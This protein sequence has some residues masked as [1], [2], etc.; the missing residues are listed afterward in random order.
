M[1]NISQHITVLLRRHDCVIVPSIGAFIVDRKHASLSADGSTFT[2][3]QR[4]V[5]FNADITHNDGLLASSIAR[6]SRISFEQASARVSA[7]VALINR[8]LNTEGAINIAGVGTLH[9]GAE[10]KIEFIPSKLRTAILPTLQINR[11][12]AKPSKVIE[13]VEQTEEKAVAVV[14]V[15]LRHRWLRAVAA[16]AVIFTLAFALS[17]PIN[18]E[19]AQ[20]AS[21][22]APMFTAPAVEK[23]EPLSTPDG[24]ELN[25]ATPPANAAMAYAKPEPPKPAEP[26]PA[27]AQQTGRQR[28]VMVVASLQS[29]QQAQQFIAADH[30]GASLQVLQSGE[31]Y[32]VYAVSGASHDEVRAKAAAIPGF[33]EKYPGA[34]VCQR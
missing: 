34:W 31:K 21:L 28:Y 29:M 17:T 11:P 20:N 18:I 8:R 32:R 4:L 14:R 7:E 10:G 30:G 22:A 27:A 5:H 23:I 19:Q 13:V 9:K 25:M 33:A 6:Q 16:I 3:P 15:P 24:L 1:R 2:P 12:A 26:K